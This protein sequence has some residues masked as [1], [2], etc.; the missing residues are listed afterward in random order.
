MGRLELKIANLRLVIQRR[1][2]CAGR[3]RSR[4][5]MTCNTHEWDQGAMVL[6]KS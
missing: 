1:I 4:G 6:E 5:F 3:T 2:H